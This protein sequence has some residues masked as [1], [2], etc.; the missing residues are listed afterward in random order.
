VPLLQARFDTALYKPYGGNVFA[1]LFS[2]IMFRFDLRP[3]LVQVNWDLSQ[4]RTNF[5]PNLSQLNP[6]STLTLCRPCWT[7]RRSCC[8]GVRCN[9]ITCSPSLSSA[10]RPGTAVSLLA[11]LSTGQG[12]SS[13]L[14]SRLAGEN[15]PSP[16]Y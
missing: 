13:W 5:N 2:R 12:P 1:W 14:C 16:S 6:N 10:D 3:D 8:G 4:L 11:R 9:H 7:R 15:Y